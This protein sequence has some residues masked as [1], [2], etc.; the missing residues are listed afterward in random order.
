M[1]YT[2]DIPKLQQDIITLFGD[3]PAMLGLLEQIIEE[4]INNGKG[5]QVDHNIKK[6]LL[7]RQINFIQ[8]CFGQFS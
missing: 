1:L 3:N 6:L 7:Y 8:I 4:I 2:S 5:L